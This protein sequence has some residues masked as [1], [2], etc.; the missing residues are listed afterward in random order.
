MWCPEPRL[1]RFGTAW[2]SLQPPH[3]PWRPCGGPMR[4]S[5]GSSQRRGSQHAAQGRA[6]SHPGSRDVLG[7]FPSQRAPSC[8]L[9]SP[10]RAAPAPV[11]QRRKV[12]PFQPPKR[13]PGSAF[14]RSCFQPGPASNTTVCD[15]AMPFR[16]RGSAH[17]EA[18][19][20]NCSS[21]RAGGCCWG[22][23]MSDCCRAALGAQKSTPHGGEM[24]TSPVLCCGKGRPAS[25]LLSSA[26]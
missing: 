25:L 12:L 26:G 6:A 18:L 13:T 1:C 23:R 24:V 14:P 22:G 21:R 3:V 19:R 8:P 20:S 5:P 17:R 2:A 15:E 7:W 16:P 11:G 9:P 4:G 10:A